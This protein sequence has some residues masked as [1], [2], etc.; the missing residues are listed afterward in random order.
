MERYE[1]PG[2]R[3]GNEDTTRGREGGLEWRKRGREEG[4]TLGYLRTHKKASLI[5]TSLKAPLMTA[6]HPGISL[7][8]S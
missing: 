4:G 5:L 6:V 7:E 3:K 8:P 2:T 1:E